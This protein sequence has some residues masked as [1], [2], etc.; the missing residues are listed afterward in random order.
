MAEGRPTTEAEPER[1][2][3]FDR[4]RDGDLHRTLR[5]FG[6]EL[7]PDAKGRSHA[8]VWRAGL[9]PFAYLGVALGVAALPWHPALR[10][11]L[12]FPAILAAQ[13]AF[14]TLVHDASHKLYSVDR[15]RNDRIASFCAAG[16]I[17]MV[18]RKYRRVH[19][20]HHSANGSTDDPEHFGFE[21]VERA[22]GWARFVLGY[23]AGLQI[24]YLLRKYYTAQDE[25][26][27]GGKAPKPSAGRRE[28]HELA[29]VLLCQASLAVA[30]ALVG[31][32]WMY[33]LW[34]YS[35][36]TWAP[37]LSRLRFLAEHPGH[38]ELTLSTRGSWWERVFIAPLSFNHHLEHHLWPSLP[39]YNLPRVHQALERAG[40]FEAH[41]EY[42]ADTFVGTLRRYTQETA[43]G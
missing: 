37:M 5:D 23:A 22:G 26:L 21:V 36:V 34:L 43:D 17:G 19:L 18:V 32:W 14:L 16:F 4:T 24:A 41:A 6:F 15:K 7:P 8:K 31:A 28:P 13:R 42:A 30:F 35:A 12:A 3:R 27:G 11:L 25:Y 10:G 2:V 29:S 40:F 39:P 20:A 33:G 9:V 1:G 38:G